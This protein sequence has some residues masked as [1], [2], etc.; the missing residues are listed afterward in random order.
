MSKENEDFLQ[1]RD[2]FNKVKVEAQLEEEKAL[3]VVQSL[4]ETF[5]ELTEE[6]AI[7]EEKAEEKE[8]QLFKAYRYIQETRSRK[9]VL[10][11]METDFS[12]FY[13]GVKSV[14]KERGRKL[15]GIEG[16]V[17]ELIQ[18]PKPYETAVEIALGASLQH[19]VVKEE[20]HARQ[21]IEFLKSSRQGRATFLPLS[22]IQGRY[23]SSELLGKVS[24]HAGFIGIGAI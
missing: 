17:A 22:A 11:E 18:V 12:G 2:S 14:L 7:L 8:G 24:Q 3:K 9:K 19:I 5:R 10:E 16:A 15:S 6:Q 21:A 20:S 13:Q 23:L 4:T 1:E